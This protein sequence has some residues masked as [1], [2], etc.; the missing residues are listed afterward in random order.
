MALMDIP[1]LV[2]TIQSVARTVRPSGWFICAVLHQCYNTPR[3]DEMPSEQGWLRLVGSYFTESHWRSE[4]RTGPPGKVGAYHRTLSTYFNALLTAGFQ[5]ER[6]SEPQAS[7]S[8]A[9]ARP[10]WTEVPAI[11]SHHDGDE[12][13]Q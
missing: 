2:P 5:L 10:I 12:T 6:M 13:E 4:K 7:G 1:D 8:R 3:S 11:N 9:A